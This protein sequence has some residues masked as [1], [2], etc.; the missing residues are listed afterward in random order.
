MVDIR[1]DL[2]WNANNT[3]MFKRVIYIADQ[4]LFLKKKN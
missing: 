4:G 3:E 2:L 1:E